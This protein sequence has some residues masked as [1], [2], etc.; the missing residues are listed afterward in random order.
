M[1]C[2]L[3]LSKTFLK[4][5]RPDYFKGSLLHLTVSETMKKILR[6]SINR[7]ESN[8][9]QVPQT[10]SLGKVT[11]STVIPHLRSLDLQVSTKKGQVLLKPVPIFQNICEKPYTQPSL[12]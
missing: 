8:P 6:A 5:S 11:F 9:Q 10:Y 3:Y 7:Q 2:E 12:R 4:Q 1:V